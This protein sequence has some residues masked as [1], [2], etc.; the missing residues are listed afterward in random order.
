MPKKL[1]PISLAKAKVPQ[2]RKPGSAKGTV[3]MAPGFDQTP[4]DFKNYR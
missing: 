3:R 2:A 1:K 4:P